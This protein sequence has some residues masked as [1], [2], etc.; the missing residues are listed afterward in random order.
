[1]TKQ[2]MKDP[3]SHLHCR[4]GLHANFSSYSQE[5]FLSVGRK[6]TPLNANLM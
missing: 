6:Q 1:M 3:D 4:P 5:I 2:K